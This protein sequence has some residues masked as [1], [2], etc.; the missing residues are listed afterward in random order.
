MLH[1]ARVTLAQ[2]DGKKKKGVPTNGI[3]AIKYL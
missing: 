3:A 1:T 2:K